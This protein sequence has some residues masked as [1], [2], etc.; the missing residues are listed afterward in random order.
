MLF[1]NYYDHLPHPSTKPAI[2]VE[3]PPCDASGSGSAGAPSFTE[4]AISE[5]IPSTPE[6]MLD[7]PRFP[8]GDDGAKDSGMELDEN[9]SSDELTP[10]DDTAFTSMHLANEKSSVIPVTSAV[11]E[12]YPPLTRELNLSP[13]NLGHF[14]ALPKLLI[15]PSS[16]VCGEAPTAASNHC[17]EMEASNSHSNP[18]KTLAKSHDPHKSHDQA[19][20][21]F[22]PDVLTVTESSSDKVQNYLELD[23][24]CET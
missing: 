6:V 23:G 13:N 21:I 22:S 24:S 20:N 1:Q 18:N 14:P 12:P 9:N 19:P 8:R 17:D 16:L 2:H 5:S 11:Q 7:H 4:S 10:T 3:V 15:P